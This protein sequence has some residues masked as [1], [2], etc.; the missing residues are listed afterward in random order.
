MRTQHLSV[1]AFHF[2]MLTIF[3]FFLS[4]ATFAVQ[5]S[6]FQTEELEGKLENSELP[7]STRFQLTLQLI[8]LYEKSAQFKAQAEKSIALF[9]TFNPEAKSDTLKKDILLKALSHESELRE[10]ELKGNL[11]LKLAGAYF[12]LY[13]FD[14]AILAYSDALER[15][16]NQDSIYIADTYFFRAQAE[17][18]QGNF[19]RAMQDYHQ[20]Q[21][22]YEALG[23]TEYANYVRAGAAIL[24]SKYGLYAEA[25]SVRQELISDAASKGEV[26]NQITQLYNRA[27]DLKKQGLSSLQIKNLLKADSLRQTGEVRPYIPPILLFSIS[28]FFG[29]RLQLDS[30]ELYFNRAVQEMQI[31]SE[32]NENHN[33][34]LIAKARIELIKGNP[35]IALQLGNKALTQAES[36]GDMDHKLEAYE[37]LED[38]NEKLGNTASA[39]Q[40]LKA[41]N[42][43]QDSIFESNQRNS[44]SYFQTLYETEKKEKAVLEKS[45]EVENLK[46]VSEKRTTL[47]TFSMVGLLALGGFGFLMIRLKSSKKEKELQENFSREL[48]KTQE[49]ERKRISKDLHDGLGQSLLLIKNKVI[50]NQPENAGEMLDT[51]INELR[52]IARSLHPM[53]LE[54]LG[55]SMA[56]EQMLDQIDRETELFVSTDIEDLKNKIPKETELQLYRIAQ[57][58]INNILKHAEAEALR[59]NLNITRGKLLLLIEDNGKGFDFSEKYQDFQSLGLKTL[60]ERTASISGVMNINSE[61]GKGTTLRFFVNVD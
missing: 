24:F 18:Y 42:H 56:L 45:M 13:N 47:F 46:Q 9:H 21:D 53:Q 57:E 17:D 12:N 32:V 19:L 26:E 44:F 37:L 38:A 4:P 39:L 49:E 10:S 15:F 7:D 3:F 41:R 52:S 20:A 5:D 36:S 43:Y 48:L 54:K 50:L 51:A 27:N 58:A 23:D 31:S 30:A 34:Y 2:L 22:I 40:F 1:G 11:H 29:E 61:K 16:T 33:S 6:I 28:K 59:V 8:H 35:S 25:D 60:K 14:S 55:L